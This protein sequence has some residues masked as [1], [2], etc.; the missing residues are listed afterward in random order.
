VTLNEFF[1]WL[2]V[3][4]SFVYL[5]ITHMADVN[6][7]RSVITTLQ[8][9]EQ[10]ALTRDQAL[11][12]EQATQAQ[13]LQDLK[14]QLANQQ[15]PQDIL[16]QVQAIQDTSDRIGQAIGSTPSDTSTPADSASPAQP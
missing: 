9:H 3:V 11:A 4:V 13:Q 6:A 15:I 14:D 8:Q 1:L 10:D 12:A 5:R 16:D 2:A 7:L